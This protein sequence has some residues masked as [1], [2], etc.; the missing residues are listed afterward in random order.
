MRLNNIELINWFAKVI[1]LNKLHREIQPSSM[2]LVTRTALVIS[3]GYE[4]E[5]TAIMR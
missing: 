5:Q 4:Y 3:S 1:G 2:S